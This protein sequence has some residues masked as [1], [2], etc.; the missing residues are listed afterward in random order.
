MSLVR[1]QDQTLEKH[2]QW[3]KNKQIPK[4][5]IWIICKKTVLFLKIQHL[6]TCLHFLG[7]QLCDEVFF[8][9][10]NFYR[11]Y[12]E[13]FFVVDKLLDRQNEIKSNKYDVSRIMSF[14]D[15]VSISFLLLLYILLLL[16]IHQ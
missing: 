11:K 3:I 4:K 5:S 8:V 15:K 2:T 6:K 7:K 1:S 13:F 10:E 14:F 16:I 12:S 9:I